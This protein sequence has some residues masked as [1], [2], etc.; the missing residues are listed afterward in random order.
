MPGRD[1]R[2]PR[3]EGPRTGWGMG[4]CPPREGE[5]LPTPPEGVVYGLGR[6]GLPRGG[7][8]G[9]GGGR[10]GGRG[11]GG[12]WGRR[13]GGGIRFR[14]RGATA[15]GSPAPPPVDDNTKETEDK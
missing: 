10:G 6:G 3:G 1:H 4:D 11:R 9:W 15:A 2:G 5:Q 8:R 7:G 14:D 13:M 12:G